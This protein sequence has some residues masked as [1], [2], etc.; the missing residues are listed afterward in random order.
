MTALASHSSATPRV[1]FSVNVCNSDAQ[2]IE[3]TIPHMLNVLNYDFIERRVA[4]D[5]GPLEG[6]YA[7][8]NEGNAKAISQVAMP[9]SWLQWDCR[10]TSRRAPANARFRGRCRPCPMQSGRAVEKT[11]Y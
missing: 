10:E 6:K 3:H 9:S 1:S 4:Y 7:K 8:R 5:P 2:Y 11:S